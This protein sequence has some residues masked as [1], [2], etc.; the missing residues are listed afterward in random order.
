LKILVALLLSHPLAPSPALSQAAGVLV[1][2]RCYGSQADRLDC[3]TREA[4]VSAAKLAGAE[5]SID[6]ALAAWDEDARYVAA[7]R[8]RLAESRAAFGRYRSAHCGFTASLGGG[9][10]GSALEM[11][12]LTCVIGINEVRTTELRALAA[13]LPLR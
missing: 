3:M 7:A 9:A 1:S 4:G 5:Q 11:R 2:E 8:A 12:R 6:S 13:Q 10:I